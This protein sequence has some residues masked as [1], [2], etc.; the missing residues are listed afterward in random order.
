MRFVWYHR[1]RNSCLPSLAGVAIRGDPVVDCR[2]PVGYVL[3]A[4]LSPSNPMTRHDAMVII[5]PPVT[6]S[7]PLAPSTF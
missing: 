1:T 6:S 3:E 2:F 4:H 7:P 5:I